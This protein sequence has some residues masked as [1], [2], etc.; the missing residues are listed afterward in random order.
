[1]S[2]RRRLNPP[3]LPGLWSLL[4]LLILLGSIFG[5]YYALAKGTHF[6]RTPEKVEAERQ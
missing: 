6:Q 4:A 3:W 1:M 2:R 5:F